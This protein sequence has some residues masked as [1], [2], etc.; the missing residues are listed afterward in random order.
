MFIYSIHAKQGSSPRL[1]EYQCYDYKRTF[2]KC[3]VTQA[4]SYT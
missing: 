2:S 1:K 4:I 3:A